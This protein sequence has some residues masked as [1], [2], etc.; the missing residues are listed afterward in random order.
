M[1]LGEMRLVLQRKVE[2]GKQQNFVHLPGRTALE[3]QFWTV[4]GVDLV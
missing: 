2:K 4:S 1:N 3:G